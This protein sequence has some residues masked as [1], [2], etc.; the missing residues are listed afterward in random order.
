M[1][2][3]SLLFSGY[4]AKCVASCSRVASRDLSSTCA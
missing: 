2:P 3:K 1:S 4:P